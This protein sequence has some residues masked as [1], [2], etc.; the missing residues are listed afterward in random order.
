MTTTADVAD[1]SVTLDIL[2]KT[3]EFLSLKECTFIGDKAYDVKKIYNTVKNVYSGECCIPINKR[4]TKN[5]DKL[6]SGRSL[7]DTGLAMNKDGKTTDNGRTRQKYCCPFKNSKTA[8]CPCNHKNWKN[9]KKTAV[10]SNI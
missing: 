1:S 10:V 2:E 5:P 8:C 4:N 6:P 7:C 3:N 9:G